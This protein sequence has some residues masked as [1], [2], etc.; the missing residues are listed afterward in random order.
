MILEEFIDSED[1]YQ[2]NEI[3]EKVMLYGIGYKKRRRQT[4]Q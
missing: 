3:M 1:D 2:H 4:G